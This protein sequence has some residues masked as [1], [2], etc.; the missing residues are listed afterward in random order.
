MTDRSDTKP[1][2]EAI[3]LPEAQN[4]PAVIEPEGLPVPAPQE[5]ADKPQKIEPPEKGTFASEANRNLLDAGVSMIP[6]AGGA[7]ANLGRHALPSER[8]KKTSEWR[9]EVSKTVN[10]NSEAINVQENKTRELGLEQEKLKETVEATVDQVSKLSKDEGTGVIEADPFDG[11]F[12]IYRQLVDQE[13]FQTALTLL[14]SRFDQDPCIK[15]HTRARAQSLKAICLKGL[16]DDRSAAEHFLDALKLDPENIKHRGNSVVAQLILDDPASA[17]ETVT[18]LVADEP[19]NPMHWANLIYARSAMGEIVPDDDVPAKFLQHEDVSLARVVTLRA[20]DDLRWKRIA[21]SS[22]A[23]NPD[24]KGLSRAVAEADIDDA[25]QLKQNGSVAAGELALAQQRTQDAAKVLLAQWQDHAAS[26]AFVAAPDIVLFQNTLMALHFCGRSDEGKRLINANKSIAFQ[27]NSARRAVAIFAIDTDDDDLLE[28]A[29]ADRFPGDSAPRLESALR[30]ESWVEALE[31]LELDGDQLEGQ[32][33]IASDYMAEMLRAALEPDDKRDDAFAKVL[34]ST[35]PDAHADLVLSR[36]ARSVGEEAASERAFERALTADLA[37]DHDA[38]I[39]LA[40]ECMNRD[41]P[42]RAVELLEGHVDTR[43]ATSERRALALA[44]ASTSVPLATGVNFFSE[45][46]KAANADEE[47]QRAGGHFHLNRR[48]PDEAVPWFRRALA[49][50]PKR[51]QTYL[52][53]WQALSRA[54]K[55]AQAESLLSD[56]VLS[57]LTG[58][59]RDQMDLAQLMWRSGRS[60]ALDHAYEIAVRNQHDLGVCLSY[61]G[62][63]LGDAFGSKAPPMPESVTVVPGS[64]VRLSRESGD[65]MQFVIDSESQDLPS[66]LA[67]DHQIVSRTLGLQVGDEFETE[68]GPSRF[69]WR[70]EEVKSKYLHLFHDLSR[71]IQDRFPENGS[72]YSL[73]IVDNDLTPI[74]ETV[75]ARRAEVERVEKLYRENPMPLAAVASAGGGDAIDFAL[76]MAQSGQQVFSATGLTQDASVEMARAKQAAEKGVVLDTYT[77]W[78]LSKLRLLGATAQAFQRVIAPA[79]LLDELAAKIEDLRKHEDGRITAG[80]EGDELV[81]IHQSAEV[82]DAYAADFSDVVAD[83]RKNASVVGIEASDD[84]STEIRQLSEFL[85]TQFDTLSVARR[86]GASLL[87]ADLRLRQIAVGVM[88]TDAFGLDALLEHLLEHCLITDEKKAEA[89]LTLAELRHSY[90]GLT[91]PTLVKMLEIDESEGLIRFT[92][93]AEYFG[94]TGGDVRSHVKTAAAFA[95]LAFSRG[96]MHQKAS[97]ATGQ[98]LRNLIRFDNVQLK[99]IVNSFT[100][101]AD[102]PDVTSYV[103]GWLRG[104]FLMGLYEAQVEAASGGQ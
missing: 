91:A 96:H 66:H 22:L 80:S 76:H 9:A 88:E 40:L 85:G 84:V 3:K 12:A 93:V 28:A 31:I 19:E 78:V 81:P 65:P 23:L 54:G 44:Y 99:D 24:S 86:E 49:A 98:I 7:L 53:L 45:V 20:H 38:R 15:E 16:G 35:D 83:I 39:R 14:T 18:Q 62:L 72:F 26:E 11:E 103:A 6:V 56:V 2:N 25:V 30:S 43:T 89:L 60:D 100:R 50:D 46:R 33:R 63:V 68:S 34:H 57:Q 71:S 42:E 64:F 58:G 82:I 59:L 69:R 8:D 4:L 70:V 32:S 27:D 75:K 1:E 37:N 97:T 94:R 74:L 10:R 90:I 79:S 41:I 87:S 17:V 48:R 5:A 104:H 21:R 102:D 52:A 73:T 77:A 51:A 29:L 92:Q 95:S 47:I 101:W 61:V 67:E 55:V 13:K 36:L